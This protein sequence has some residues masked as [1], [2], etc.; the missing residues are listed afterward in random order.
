MEARKISQELQASLGL[1]LS[2]S[3]L[4]PLLFLKTA[5]LFS[6][7]HIFPDMGLWHET[8]FLCSRAGREQDFPNMWSRQNTLQTQNWANH[9]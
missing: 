6:L 3:H 2:L 9:I 1:P 8:M 5:T 4:T 7:L